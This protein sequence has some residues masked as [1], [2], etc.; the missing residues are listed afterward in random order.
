MT[1]FN[2]RAAYDA[3]KLL[4]GDQGVRAFDMIYATVN[5]AELRGFNNGMR[6]GYAQGT[7]KGDEST[8]RDGWNAGFKAGAKSEDDFWMREALAIEAGPD[9]Q[10]LDADFDE[11]E[12]DDFPVSGRRTTITRYTD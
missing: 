1:N 11:V 10:L 7:V 4:V 2:G 6:E 3:L 9:I 8:F 5:E 12:E